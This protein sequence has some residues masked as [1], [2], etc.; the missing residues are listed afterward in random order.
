MKET[1]TLKFLKTE[2]LQHLKWLFL[3]KYVNI[4]VIADEDLETLQKL[5]IDLEM[6]FK[7]PYAEYIHEFN[8]LRKAAF[9]PS[10]QS[11]KM[12]QQAILSFT[13]AQIFNSLKNIFEDGFYGTK[14]E[15]SRLSPESCLNV[16]FI[17]KYLNKDKFAESQ[18]QTKTTA[19]TATT[20]QYQAD[21]IF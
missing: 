6:E 11:L 1:P 3:N 14:K 4:P 15:V 16:Q 12:Y 7:T 21:D 19:N 8:R 17:N 18:T 13:Q 10:I 20:P 9:A 5:I 2:S